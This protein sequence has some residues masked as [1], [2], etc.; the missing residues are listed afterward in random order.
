MLTLAV[1][2]WGISGGQ[3]SQ[4][5]GPCQV[6]ARAIEAHRIILRRSV[7]RQTQKHFRRIL[8][9]IHTT[10]LWGHSSPWA[11][12]LQ[13]TASA[14]KVDTQRPSVSVTHSSLI[15]GT[16]ISHIPIFYWH[17]F[18]ILWVRR[19]RLTITYTGVKSFVL[20][21][22]QVRCFLCLFSFA[23]TSLSESWFLINT[24]IP[25]FCCF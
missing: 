16:H 18:C 25:L 3:R 15:F 17:L 22:W 7:L 24:Q 19:R 5:G 9:G 14:L 11:S 1:V 8:T 12:G 23:L 2:S 21:V 4:A 6:S 20:S 10:Q 13:W